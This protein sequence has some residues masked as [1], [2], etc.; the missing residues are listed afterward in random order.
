MNRNL[1]DA[2]RYWFWDWYN[3]GNWDPDDGDYGSEG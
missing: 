2:L 3:G 1:W